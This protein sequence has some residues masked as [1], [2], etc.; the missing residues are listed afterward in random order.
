MKIRTRQ[1]YF[2]IIIT[3]LVF[4]G[5]VKKPD[6]TITTPPNVEGNNL[7]QKADNLANKTLYSNSNYYLKKAI[8]TFSQTGHWEE[9][10]RNHIKI[11][12][13]YQRIDQYAVAGKH[14]DTALE[15]AKS[16][17]S[18]KQIDIA[19]NYQK[20]AHSYL[21]KGDFTGA[22]D[23]YQKALDIRLRIQGAQHPQVAKIYN[24]ISQ[25]YWNM[26]DAEQ[27]RSYY[28]KSLYIKIRFMV[29][30]RFY[31]MVKSYKMM[32]RGES[33]KQNFK[34]AKDFFNRA[35][36]L[37]KDGHHPLVADVYENIGIIST[38]EADYERALDFFGKAIRSRVETFGE[39]SLH[40][41]RN[42]HN[43][44]ICLAFKGDVDEAEDY[45][46]RALKIKKKALNPLHPELADTYYQLGKVKLAK[47]RL[48]E[49]LD[50]FQLGIKATV[51]GLPG[52]DIYKNPPIEGRFSQ[53]T[54]LKLLTAKAEALSIK[55]AYNPTENQILEFSLSTYLLAVQL[56]EKTRIHYKSEDYKL[57]FGE[58]CQTIFDQAIQTAMN[59]YTITGEY[60]YKVTALEVS[61]KSKAAVLTEA[62]YESRARE[63]SGIPQDLL[64]KEKQLKEKL[65]AYG[66]DLEGEFQSNLTKDSP[67]YRGLEKKYFAV[68]DEYQK[69]IEYFEQNYNKYYQLKY[70]YPEVSLKEIQS[71]IPPDTT[72]VEYFVG[73][74][75]IYIFIIRAD[76]FEA[77]DVPKEQA[78]EA[79]VENF[80]NSIKKIEEKTFVDLSQKLYQKLMAPVTEFAPAKGKLVII[81]HGSLYFIPFE[82]FISSPHISTGNFSDLDYL[83]KRYEFSYHY[84]ARLWLYSRETPFVDKTQRFIG[85]A[86][87]FSD[88]PK[89]G[90]IID[91]STLRSGGVDDEEARSFVIHKDLFSELPATERELRNIIDMFKVSA[92]D[93][94]GFFH[95][96]A[97]EDAFKSI[98]MEQYS[99]V[100]I[101]THSLKNMNNPA[102]SGLIFARPNENG[103]KNDGILFASEAYNLNLNARLIVL[104]SCESGIGKLINGEGM[105]AMH[106]GFFYS[107]AQNI[108]FSLWKIEDKATSTL[109][110]EFYKN[111]LKKSR[112]PSALRRAKLRMIRNPY[113]A[114]PKYWSGFILLGM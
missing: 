2:T 42:F 92:G 6:I 40:L 13:N 58:K 44:G 64:D 36:A 3:L 97:T 76:E 15:L 25:V 82:T 61:E 28:N 22:L 109:M 84:S 57:Y 87:I 27:A 75:N 77:I 104:S 10:I 21:T 30:L 66:T 4:G 103:Q 94:T 55:F 52:N 85:F 98:N 83:V 114:F 38:F 101:A 60:K 96:Q 71:N 78:F 49:A 46:Q 51:P 24:S 50:N 18:L 74:K 5:C 32:D 72:I 67:E 26:G 47:E 9:V 91:T 23:S 90:Y 88:Q 95:R 17:A 19:S 41:A 37:N 111:I 53:E 99:F 65:V 73:E 56:I 35:L 112:F 8:T 16:Y 80:H 70:R 108:I 68:S 110:V 102:M 106:R 43:I 31:N 107:G 54:L 7:T 12:D 86:P 29:G 81:P 14:L 34:Q 63:F 59:L 113:T 105:M 45:L 48:D 33:G 39:D 1:L 100:H 79:S 89:D 62:L 93:A 11:G 20:M 69:L